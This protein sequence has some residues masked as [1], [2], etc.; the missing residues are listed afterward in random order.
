[1]SRYVFFFL[2]IKKN[3]DFS[4]RYVGFSKGIPVYLFFPPNVDDTGSA[5]LANPQNLDIGA[6][7]GMSNRFPMAPW[8][9]VG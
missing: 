4:V 3:S 6:M 1:M 8:G 9:R 2:S 5:R 7:L